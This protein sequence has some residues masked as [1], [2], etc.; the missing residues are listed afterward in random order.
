MAA[1]SSS[2]LQHFWRTWK[3]T[4]KVYMLLSSVTC[5]TNLLMSQAE[6]CRSQQRTTNSAQMN[7]S[8]QCTDLLICV[9]KL[10]HKYMPLCLFQIV[11]V[12]TI[13]HVQLFK[14]D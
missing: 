11:C 12:N 1:K 9:W 13:R 4:G 8:E 5:D 2:T 3:S 6:A 7:G 10:S 14:E